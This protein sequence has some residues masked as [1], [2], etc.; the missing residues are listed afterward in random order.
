MMWP[1]WSPEGS[2]K[3]DQSNGT[4]PLYEKR[5]KE[6]ELFTVEIRRLWGDLRGAF[7][8]LERTY[9]KAG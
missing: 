9:Q 6:L 1:Y 7:L 8:Y 5:L 2:N 4:I 3:N